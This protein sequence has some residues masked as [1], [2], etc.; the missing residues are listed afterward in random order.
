MNP[1]RTC[2]FEDC[3]SMCEGRTD[4]CAHHNREM[5]RKPKEVK[6]RTRINPVSDKEKE[7]QSEYNAQVKEWK[8]GKECALKPLLNDH[9]HLPGCKGS[10]TNH[11]QRGKI[12]D[13]LFDEEFWLPVCLGH[14]QYVELHPEESYQMGWSLLRLSSEPHKI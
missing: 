4:Y 8:I 6:P 9:T 11:H 10:L 2:C 1:I 13:L 3:E 14:H 12:G 7:R 5:R